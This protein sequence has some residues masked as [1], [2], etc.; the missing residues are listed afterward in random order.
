MQWTT[1]ELRQQQDAEWLAYM[2]GIGLSFLNVWT[3]C[4]GVLQLLESSPSAAPLVAAFAATALPVSELAWALLE[5]L[6]PSSTAGSGS[7]SSN[8]SSTGGSRSKGSKRNTQP[9]IPIGIVAS[10]AQPV[11]RTLEK[12]LFFATHFG[13]FAVRGL[14]AEPRPA[15]GS[16]GSA[17]AA[18]SDAVLQVLLLYLACTAASIQQQ[19]QTGAAPA[20]RGTRSSSSRRKSDAP[21]PHMSLLHA[22]APAL[23][24]LPASLSELGFMHNIDHD[25]LETCAAAGMIDICGFLKTRKQRLQPTVAS[26]GG[27][28]AASCSVS[29]SS[30]SSTQ[31]VAVL[32]RD[33]LLLPLLLTLVELAELQPEQ[34]DSLLLPAAVPAM[35]AVIAEQRQ[36]LMPTQPGMG[37]HYAAEEAAAGTAVADALA[38]PVFLQLG[39]AVMR[40]LKE[41]AAAAPAGGGSNAAAPLAEADAKVAVAYL[42]LVQVVLR[43]SE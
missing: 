32:P 31:Q 27:A 11:V 40:F 38:A 37:T 20:A 12:I 36:Q 21:A 30:S 26:S 14:A 42:L 23:Q 25:E 1:A 39:P 13:A 33:E 35:V 8:N 29:S 16:V 19:Q 3:C 7:S 2:R 43:N 28:I 5:T 41:A 17:E 6:T 15:A 10:A 34:K 22:L 24:Q 18:R 4:R 9:V